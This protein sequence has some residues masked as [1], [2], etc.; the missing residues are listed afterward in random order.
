MQPLS[1]KYRIYRFFP[2][3]GPWW[4]AKRRKG[5][6]HCLAGKGILECQ[7]E[8]DRI[9]IQRLLLPG[10]RGFFWEVDCGDGT[11]GS[12]SLCLESEY[13]WKGV[14]WE[15]ARIPREAASRNRR[16]P[17]RGSEP[18]SECLLEE[19]P[20]DLLV[21]RRATEHGWIWGKLR[22]G[23]IRPDWILIQNPSPDPVWAKLLET[24]GYRLRWFF[25]DDEYY[26]RVRN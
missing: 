16:M 20:P 24:E 8:Q 14:L 4:H 9:F 26:H 19:H 12:N 1:F 5:L 10:S 7:L 17:V 21:L 15:G 6:Q 3:W 23:R 25:H 18:S 11:T 2:S 13:G 22:S